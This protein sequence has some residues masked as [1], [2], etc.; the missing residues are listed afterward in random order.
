MPSPFPGMNQY[1]EQPDAWSDFF[2]ASRRRH[3]RWNCDWSSDVCSSDLELG[4]LRVG[5]AV[6][7]GGDREARIEALLAVGC[8]VICIDTAHGHSA[9][10]LEAVRQTRKKRSEERRVGKEGRCR[11]WRH[12]SKKE[13]YHGAR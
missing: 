8:D 9:G 11:G 10:V 4:R 12:H 2:F 13:R 5:A 7:V 3:T 6:G 1:L